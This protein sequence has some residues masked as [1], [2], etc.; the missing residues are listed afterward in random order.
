MGPAGRVR[1]VPKER[2]RIFLRRAEELL[3]FMRAAHRAGK[4]I[5][6]GV[7]GVQCAIALGDA[8]S[9]AYLGQVSAGQVSAGQAHDEAVTLLARSGARGAKEHA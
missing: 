9:A 3:E 2:Y 6:A 4:G 8:V 5:A 7:N 1:S